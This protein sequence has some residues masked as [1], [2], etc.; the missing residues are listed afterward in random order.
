MNMQKFLLSP[1]VENMI[2]T[3]KFSW[4]QSTVNRNFLEVSYSGRT[5]N[6]SGSSQCEVTF[7]ALKFTV[8]YRYFAK[9]IQRANSWMANLWIPLDKV[10]PPCSADEDIFASVHSACPNRVN[11]LDKSTTNNFMLA[12]LKSFRQ[13]I[14]SKVHMQFDQLLVAEICHYSQGFS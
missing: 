11:E 10:S 9:V 8:E 14:T 3:K 5:R 1:V 6:F 12:R 2:N 4:K 13:S 7:I